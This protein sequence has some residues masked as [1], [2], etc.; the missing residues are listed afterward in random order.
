MCGT[1]RG[2]RPRSWGENSC[3]YFSIKETTNPQVWGK[4]QRALSKIKC[5]TTNQTSGPLK[6]VLGAD[7]KWAV[8]WGGDTAA[9]LACGSRIV[10]KGAPQV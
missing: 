4:I 6:D 2:K 7:G 8:D 3:S 10:Q 1:V 9:G 5:K